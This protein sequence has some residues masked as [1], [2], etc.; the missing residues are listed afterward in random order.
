M[1][2][3]ARIATLQGFDEQTTDRQTDIQTAVDIIKCG[4]RSVIYIQ[5]T[6]M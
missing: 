1:N 4:A 3:K 5:C 6:Y 2:V